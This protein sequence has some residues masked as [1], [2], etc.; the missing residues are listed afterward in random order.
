MQWA[1]AITGRRDREGGRREEGENEELRQRHDKSGSA[2]VS[3]GEVCIRSPLIGVLE[4][5]R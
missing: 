5:P 2:R 4:A 1:E 3:L